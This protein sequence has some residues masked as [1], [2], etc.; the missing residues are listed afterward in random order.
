MSSVEASAGYRG[1]ISSR[2]FM[3]ERVAQHVQNL[4]I[5]DYAGRHKLAYK[6]SATEYAMPG[7]FMVLTSV[8]SELP[9]LEGVIAY[10]LFML[11]AVRARRQD[12][13]AS[14]LKEGKPLHFALEALCMASAADA[15]HVETLWQ[16]RQ[17]TAWQER[18]AQIASYFDELN[19]VAA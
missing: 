15:D 6:L 8:L 19:R 1:Y 7:C 12:V 11:P 13:Y 4:V 5:R 10:S 3:G 17:A 9:I 2:P 14:F 16:V 18:R